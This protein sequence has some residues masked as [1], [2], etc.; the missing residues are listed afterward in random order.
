M[1]TG[2]ILEKGKI[3][4][5]SPNAGGLRIVVD[6]PKI[7][8]MIEVGDSVSVNGSCLTAVIISPPVIE[9]DAVR[10]TVVRT[11]ISGLKPGDRVNLEPAL[12][13]GDELGGHMVLGHVDGMGSISGITESG[14]ET[15]FRIQAGPGIMQ[16][17]V[18][19][20]SI[21]VDGISLTVADLNDDWFEV[22][23]IPHTIENTT[24]A[25]KRT[26]NT[27]N[28]E[29]DIIGKYVFK[30][31]GKTAGKSDQRLLGK[32]AEGGFLD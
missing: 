11:T 4:R 23:V 25:E 16:Y 31:V 18:E 14:S 20:G 22:A 32:L 9:F 2:L 27:V 29:T 24:L 5:I 12:R 17:V 6:A 1:F 15:R 8:G 3:A 7:S 13:V 19:K 10:E 26:N 28:L 30:Y 21:A